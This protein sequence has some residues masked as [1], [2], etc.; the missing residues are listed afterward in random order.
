MSRFYYAGEV[1]PRIDEPRSRRHAEPHD[2]RNSRLTD[3][4]PAVN[5]W[6]RFSPVKLHSGGRIAENPLQFRYQ[7]VTP[8][9]RVEG[10]SQ[11]DASAP[12]S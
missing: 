12:T 9:P 2:R 10:A 11:W 7:Q 4:T 5:R 6:C 8:L 1:L 3:P